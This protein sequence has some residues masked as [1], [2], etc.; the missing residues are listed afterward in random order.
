MVVALYSHKLYVS[1]QDDIAFFSLINPF[2]M[3]VQGIQPCIALY[4]KEGPYTEL[5]LYPKQN[6]FESKF[7]LVLIPLKVQHA[8]SVE[9]MML[10]MKSNCE[11]I[12]GAEGWFK[13]ILAYRALRRQGGEH[14]KTVLWSVRRVLMDSCKPCAPISW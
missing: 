9:Q 12:N 3:F 5:I 7:F 8:D 14:G 13:Q 11:K 4:L 10:A 6:A 1:D 2:R